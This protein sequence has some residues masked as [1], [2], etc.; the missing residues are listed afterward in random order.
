VHEVAL[1]VCQARVAAL[2]L[3]RLL[4][5]ALNWMVGAA[6]CTDTV[7]LCVA[8]P[9]APVRVRVRVRVQVSTLGP[10]RKSGKKCHTHLRISR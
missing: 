5:V 8:L 1:A 10:D 4:G 7:A 3:E 6:A 9:P 2:P